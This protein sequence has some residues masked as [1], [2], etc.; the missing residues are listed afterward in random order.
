MLIGQKDARNA[1]S[2][3]RLQ[4]FR[5]WSD[6]LAIQPIAQVPRTSGIPPLLQLR[7]VSTT[8]LSLFKIARHAHPKARLL[9][10]LFELCSWIGFDSQVRLPSAARSRLTRPSAGAQ[11]A[12]PNSRRNPFAE[13]R[14]C[15]QR[16]RQ[17]PRRQLFAKPTA[18]LPPV[19]PRRHLGIRF[20]LARVYLALLN[21]PT[22]A[23]TVS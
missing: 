7:L 1:S 9:T 5:R 13:R 23:L 8:S 3:Q 21:A 18:S 20:S 19:N 6:V 2:E 22:P 15:L 17:Q 10:I 12:A 16:T 4:R 14:L 11:G